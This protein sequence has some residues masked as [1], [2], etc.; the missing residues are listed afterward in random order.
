MLS[1][2]LQSQLKTHVGAIWLTLLAG[3]FPDLVTGS[4]MNI[5][6]WWILWPIMTISGVIMAILVLP[7][8]RISIFNKG[9]SIFVLATLAVYTIIPSYP[10]YLVLLLPFL[11]LFGVK[12]MQ[13]VIKKNRMMFLCLILLIYG[14]VNAFFFLLP[15]PDIPL[16]GFYY[17]LSH[18]FFQD[19]YQ[20][21][22]SNINDLGL[23]RNQFRDIAG[24]A[25]DGAKIK[26]ID[27]KELSK[28]IPIFASEGS[29]K[30]RE[31]YKTQDLGEFY[32]DKTIKLV[33]QNDE[34]K[35]KWDWSLVFNGFL[36][37]Y[38]METQIIPGK[39]G[40]IISN[41][42]M[43]L[44]E[45]V[46][47]YLISVNPE[48]I[49]LSKEQLML[50]T[51]SAYGYKDGVNFQNA[52]LENVLPSSSVPI[53]TTSQDLSHEN[54]DNLLSFPGITLSTYK[55][56]VF[57]NI[58]PMSIDNLF[59]KECCTRIYSS[60]NY[61][62]IKGLEEQYDSTLWGY[63]GGKIL[64]EDSKGA[65]IRVVFV[66]DKKDGRDVILQ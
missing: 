14:L 5:S 34:W 39:R 41:N 35:I 51:F 21:D 24:K 48:K 15:K 22:I 19:I 31:E 33:K 18:L 66:K 27:V 56:R 45:D 4:L 40:S 52:Y 20:E 53:F 50:K 38:K 1:I 64:L 23:T 59:Y 6:Q 26:E 63:S 25:L 47:G 60:Y 57:T 62:G 61:H 55:S 37:N 10:R 2:Y 36:P 30:I 11:Y 58:N 13:I 49:N 32:E 28:N 3:K 43:Y 9:L 44:A 7:S 12:F 65:I 29:V 17:N 16:N 54:K 42:G 8:K 46:D